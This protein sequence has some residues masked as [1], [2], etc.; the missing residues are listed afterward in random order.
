MLRTILEYAACTWSPHHKSAIKQ[1]ESVQRRF[2]K[3]LSG[4]AKV[5]N[6]KVG[7]LNNLNYNYIDNLEIR[8][9]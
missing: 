3:I 9:L 4:L 7:S 1:I 6:M 2:T 8:R 5:A